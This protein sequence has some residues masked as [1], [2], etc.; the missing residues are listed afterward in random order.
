MLCEANHGGINELQFGARLVAS[1]NP[2][3]LKNG[4]IQRSRRPVSRVAALRGNVA[5]NQADARHTICFRRRRRVVTLV[6]GALVDRALVR[7]LVAWGRSRLRILIQR[8]V[9]LSVVLSD[10]CAWNHDRQS[11][12]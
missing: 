5:M 10:D 1:L 3:T 6:A 7:S 9:V 8:L 11:Q 2:V 12:S 4:S